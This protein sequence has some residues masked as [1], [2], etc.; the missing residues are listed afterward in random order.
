MH[1]AVL[2]L[3]SLAALAQGEGASKSDAAK[4]EGTWQVEELTI[5]GEKMEVPTG[6]VAVVKGGTFQVRCGELAEPKVTLKLD[7]SKKLK[8]VDFMAGRE[9]V[10]GSGIYEIE[11]DRLRICYA[12]AGKRPGK[13]ASEKGSG[14]R[15]LVL[16][17]KAK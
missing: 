14:V 17:R 3:G 11:G 10:V 13:F 15:L 12:G 1:M 8:E 16:K 7:E 4:I 6:M 5:G 9:R 2:L